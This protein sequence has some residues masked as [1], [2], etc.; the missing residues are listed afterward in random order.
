LSLLGV[1]ALALLFWL[2]SLSSLNSLEADQVFHGFWFSA[3]C[4]A[5][6]LSLGSLDGQQAAQ[7][8]GLFAL[9]LFAGLQQSLACHLA[10]WLPFDTVSVY[11]VLALVILAV[12]TDVSAR[13]AGFSHRARL[14][15]VFALAT[16][17]AS[18]SRLGHLDQVLLIAVGPTLMACWQLRSEMAAATGAAFAP[19]VLV[20]GAWAGVMTFPAQEYYAVFSLLILTSLALLSTL[21][22]MAHAPAAK[23]MRHA[24]WV[25]VQFICGF[26]LVLAVAFLPK[27][28]AAAVPGPPS[29]WMT[30]RLPTEQ[31]LY[32]MMPMTWFVPPPLLEPVRMALLEAGF[33]VQLESFFW[34][35]GSLLIPLGLVVAVWRL[36]RPAEREIKPPLE[37]RRFFAVLLLM[38]V[39]LAL[40]VMTM[41]GLGTLFAT[42]V[43]PVLRSLN[44][45]SV[46]VYGASVVY[47]ISEFDAWL[48]SH[49]T[50][51]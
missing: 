17:P 39:F 35:A 7:P 8:A 49:E 14:L 30:P 33:A 28:V 2:P 20:H 32:G 9:S 46:F 23:A 13:Q 51:C 34:S 3:A 42:F 22:R 21:E 6:E 38:V 24:V 41:G 27:L 16:A 11:L 1:V 5:S 47:L 12:L 26:V 48:A 45:F 31:M 43:T 50:P 29:L 4:R 36:L 10:R 37:R 15:L 40:V 18:F 25:A 19:G 44:R